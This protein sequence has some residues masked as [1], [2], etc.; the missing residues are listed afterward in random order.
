[1][2]NNRA[3]DRMRRGRTAKT[4]KKNEPNWSN[5]NATPEKNYRIHCGEDTARGEI[6]QDQASARKDHIS[7]VSRR[8]AGAP[9]AW[10]MPPQAL[11]KHTE[12]GMLL[13]TAPPARE[14]P[15]DGGTTKQ[16]SL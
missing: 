7:Q 2:R 8:R 3:T 15:S 10:R 12:L 14:P 1:M 9:I 4:T 11:L 16:N 5:V 6:N 13:Y